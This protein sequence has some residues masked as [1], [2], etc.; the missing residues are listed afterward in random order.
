MNTLKD[1]Y[2]KIV[3]E[4]AKVTRQLKKLS[5]NEIIKKY[6]ELKSKSE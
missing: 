3:S 1:E 2:D 5:Q 6:L 4:R